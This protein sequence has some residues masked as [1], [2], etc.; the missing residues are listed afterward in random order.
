M[1]DQPRRPT[2]HGGPI[3]VY[4]TRKLYYERGL[5]S[6]PPGAPGTNRPNRLAWEMYGISGLARRRAV[7][8]RVAYINLGLWPRGQ[9]RPW[10]GTISEAIMVFPLFTCLQL[11]KICLCC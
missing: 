7:A 9:G 1:G 5:V 11:S 6:A 2:S 3:Q 8:G 4:D 10:V